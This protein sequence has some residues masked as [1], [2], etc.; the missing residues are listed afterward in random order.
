MSTKKYQHE[1]QY[2]FEV[3]TQPEVLDGFR[4]HLARFIY[5]QPHA[6]FLANLEHSSGACC[7]LKFTIKT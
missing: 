1:W 6:A 3:G 4:N 2:V 5:E 7:P